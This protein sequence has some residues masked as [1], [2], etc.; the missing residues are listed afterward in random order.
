MYSQSHFLPVI[1]LLDRENPHAGI[2]S[3]L[4]IE[5]NDTLLCKS[6]NTHSISTNITL[7]FRCIQPLCANFE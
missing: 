4:T 5:A 2:I 1:Y 6:T 3:P 7:A